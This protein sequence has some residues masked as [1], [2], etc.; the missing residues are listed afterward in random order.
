MLSFAVDSTDSTEAPPDR[1]RNAPEAAPPTRPARPDPAHA[2]RPAHD[3]HGSARRPTTRSPR[4]RS[5]AY[6]GQS[7]TDADLARAAELEAQIVAEEKAAEAA[8]AGTA[9]RVEPVP[10]PA[11]GTL[12]VA[13]AEEYAYVARD[14]RRIVLIGGSLIVLSSG[15]T[16]AGPARSRRPGRGQRLGCWSASGALRQRYAVPATSDGRDRAGEL[17][18]HP[19]VDA[20]PS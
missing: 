9:K 8:G 1:W 14:V 5:A 3:R 20:G 7:L 11:S 12:A 4:R 17:D 2:T 15:S 16:R 10:R 6:G 19:V 18:A 13:A